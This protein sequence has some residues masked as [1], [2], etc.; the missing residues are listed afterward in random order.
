MW[1]A[2][3]ASDRKLSFFDQAV[4]SSGTL[5]FY[6]PS[7]QSLQYLVPR[8]SVDVIMMLLIGDGEN[9]TCDFFAESGDGYIIEV[10]RPSMF[11]MVLHIVRS[12]LSFLATKKAVAI[13][14][15]MYSDTVVKSCTA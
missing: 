2:F 11:E 4:P 12:R 9:S 15:G 10:M 5:D 8:E 6:F 13:C 14:R 1:E 7:E 3:N